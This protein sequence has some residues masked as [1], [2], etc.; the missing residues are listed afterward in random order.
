M[1]RH[2]RIPVL[3]VTPQVKSRTGTRRCFSAMAHRPSSPSCSTRVRTNLVMAPELPTAHTLLVTSSE[4]G[5]GKTMTAANLAVSLAR[6][7]QRV[8]LIDADL[9]KPRLH[10]VFGDEQQPGLADVLSGNATH[11]LRFARRRSPGCG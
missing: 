5:E 8:L 2:L 3:G 7:N 4:P 10:E 6:L 9:R 11:E 1:K